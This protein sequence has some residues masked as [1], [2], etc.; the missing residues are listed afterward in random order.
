MNLLIER[1]EKSEKK[2]KEMAE[3]KLSRLR[4]SSGL[5]EEEWRLEGEKEEREG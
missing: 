4:K 1:R 2:K 5:P 3:K